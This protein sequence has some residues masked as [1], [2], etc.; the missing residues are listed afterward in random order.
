MTSRKARLARMQADFIANVTHELRTP[1]SSIKL[2][3]QTLQSGKLADDP[4]RTAECI[5]VILREAGW[6]DV[7][8]D[9]L[10]TWRSSS[11]EM[12]QLEMKPAPV[13]YAVRSAAEHFKHIVPADEMEFTF[14]PGSS[15]CVMHDVTAIN[16]IVLNLLVNAYK[17]T[18]NHKKISVRT[19]D[20]KDGVVIE[21]EDNGIGIE[22]H[23]INKIYE[24]FY[25]V[26]RKNGSGPGGTGLGLSIV[27]YLVSRHNGTIDVK[28]VKD[29]GSVFTINLPA[30]EKQNEQ[31]H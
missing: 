18:G 26:R 22:P 1:L 28:S 30:A 9:R 14:T 15:L 29:A 27:R 13:T 21:V 2:Y 31:A 8:I 10:L 12:M 4:K 11:R 17:Y 3:A 6:L 19:S 24:P 25:R 7:M 20:G 16:T 5:G 23:E